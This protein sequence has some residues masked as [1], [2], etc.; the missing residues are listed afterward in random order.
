V[1]LGLEFH[2]WQGSDRPQYGNVASPEAAAAKNLKTRLATILLPNHSI[3]RDTCEYGDS[4]GQQK[5][6]DFPYYSILLDT[7]RY[8]RSRWLRPVASDWRR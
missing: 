6:L 1:I 2:E 5:M 4:Y 3:L 7:T 8:G